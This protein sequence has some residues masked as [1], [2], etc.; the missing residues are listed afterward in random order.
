[1]TL[2]T[3]DTTEVFTQEF[4]TRLQQDD[5]RA[6][7]RHIMKIV[8][9]SKAPKERV[10]SARVNKVKFLNIAMSEE[11]RAFFVQVWLCNLLSLLST[12]YTLEG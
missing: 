4:M 6:H 9:S 1:M 5:F 11:A 8:D 3:S 10:Q 2:I 12:H 7:L